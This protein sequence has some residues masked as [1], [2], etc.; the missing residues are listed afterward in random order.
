MTVGK[1]DAEVD[2]I[3]KKAED[4][5]KQ[6]KKGAK[7]DELAKK[8]SEDPGSKDK[9]GDLGWLVQGQTVPEF[10][11]AAF[12]LQPGQ[13][14]DLVKTQYG[15]H[16]IK[17]LEKETAHTKPLEEVKLPLLTQLRLNKVQEQENKISD[18]I[19]AAI[20]KSNKTPLADLAKEFHLEVA[21]TRPVAVSDPLLELGNSNEVKERIFQLREGEVSQPMRTD[22]GYVVLSLK[23]VLPAHQGTLEEVRDKVSESLKQEKS[24]EIARSKAEDLSK[25]AKAGEKF[26]AVAKALGLDPKTSEDFSRAGSVPNVGSGKQLNAAFNM[27]VGEVSAPLPLGTNWVVYRIESKTAANMA[28]FDKQKK[29]L[30]DQVLNEKRALAYEA[31]RSGL[32]ERLKQE[33]KLKLMP[34]KMKNFGDLTSL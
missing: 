28:D 33:G 18:Q 9:G 16:I 14:S 31:F 24:V 21:Q 4:V 23:Q 27:K 6:V 20:R 11:K 19:A 10:E 30:T 22:R 29:E 34:E 15:F 5:F 13:V 26:D 7:F 3:K 17:V 12:S 32:E 25:R 2:E 1:T 8:N